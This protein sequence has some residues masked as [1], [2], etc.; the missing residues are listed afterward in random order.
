MVAWWGKVGALLVGVSGLLAALVSR[1]AG[2][3]GWWSLEAGLDV[4]EVLLAWWLYHRQLRGARELTDP[5]SAFLFLL[6]V[7]GLVA[8]IFT[9]IRAAL[10]LVLLNLERSFGDLLMSFW[11][12]RALGVLT[13]S[14]PLLAVLTPWLLRWKLAAPDAMIDEAKIDP[15]LR[16]WGPVDSRRLT[17]GDWIEM[18]GL[19]VGAG[20]LG[21]ALVL[22]G[23]RG[24]Q[25]AWRWWGGPL[26]LVVWACLRQGLRGGT[27]AAGAAAAF[28]LLMLMDKPATEAVQTLQGNLLIQ[29]S[30]VLLVS[31]TITWIRASEYRYRQIISHVPVV[32]YSARIPQDQPIELAEE[33]TRPKKRS[34]PILGVEVTLVSAASTGL[35]GCSPEQLLGKHQNWLQ[36]VHPDDRELVLAALSQL[37]RQKQPVTCEYRLLPEPAPE[38]TPV[39]GERA[40]Q[41]RQPRPAVRWVRDVLAPHF[42][43]EGQLTGWEGAVTDITDQR[44]LSDDLRRTT[45][46]LHALVANLP[47]GVFFVQGPEGF[48]ILVNARARQLLGQREDASAGLEHLSRVYRLHRPDGSLYPIEELPVFQAL[49]MGST[50]MRDDI[51]VHRPDNRRLRLVTWAAPVNLSTQ[52]RPEA[53]VWVLEDLTSLHQAEAARRDSETRLRTILSTMGEGL[54]LQDRRG[55]IVECNPAACTLFGY[56]RDGMRGLSFARLPW[57]F[58]REDGTPLAVEEHPVDQALRLG[59]PMR[60]VIL[61]MRPALGSSEEAGG[62]PATRWVLVNAMPLGNGSSSPGVVTTFADMTPYR[63]AQEASTVSDQRGRELE[64]SQRLELLGRLSAG[65]AQEF[66]NQLAGILNLTEG[67]H[68]SLPPEHGAQAHL[69][70]IRETGERAV[71]LLQQLLELSESDKGFTPAP[72]LVRSPDSPGTSPGTADR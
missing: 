28:P 38:E 61:G 44:V 24:N 56:E 48:P 7:P 49:R 36:R 55:D 57:V 25:A 6:V 8:G 43:L 52:G 18:L 40:E 23:E 53:A 22:L 13:L 10:A 17:L 67:M 68:A 5:R 9:L 20:L 50:T 46:M 33:G 29:C 71:S 4:G 35:L 16:I 37:R 58:L 39:N 66:H 47:A 1:P 14:P 59:R 72:P 30:T 26:L 54:I 11:L 41:R 70:G 12:S 31:A 63:Q 19:A 65:I 69:A 45:S 34:G 64:Y 62:Q 42:D 51:V 3:T 15:Q 21:L 27:L 60:N 32:L 2:W